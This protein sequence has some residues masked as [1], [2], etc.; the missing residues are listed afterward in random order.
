MP[1][2]A[3]LC[4]DS[5]WEVLLERRLGEGGFGSV[6][7][8]KDKEGSPPIDCAAKRLILGEDDL[9]REA[10]MM[11]VRILKAVDDHE[12]IVSLLGSAERK[13]QEGE[14]GWMFL[15]MATGGEL[16]DRLIDSGS[17]SER[18]AWPYFKGLVE[19]V[20]HCHSRGVVHRDL[21][22]ENVML[23]A[24]DP[25]AIRVIDFGLAVQLRRNADG[26]PDPTD[27]RCDCAG[28]QAYRAPEVTAGE[29]DPY[30]VDVWALGIMLFSLCA[31]FF[32]LKEACVDVDWRYKRLLAA[33]Q[34]D[35]D[36]NGSCDAIFRMY[37]RECPF[38]T[39]LKEL[40][41]SMLRIHPGKRLDIHAVASHLW[42][43]SAPGPLIDEDQVIV[44]RG[45]SGAAE[46][47]MLDLPDDAPPVERQ[48]AARR[49]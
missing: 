30:K 6:Y 32:P 45:M 18:A 10:Y 11:E 25:H 20:Q 27:T 40:L 1:S 48:N 39:P 38:E 9:L 36:Y 19:A 42:L 15:E 28:T 41:D 37:K 14:E 12:S 16:F 44:Y 49:R 4:I 7:R 33:Q 29:Y 35:P 17:M 26:S 5:R 47:E 34:K 2:A 8:G 21:K 43:K 22:L 3:P 13:L 46:E 23:T 31:G 24:E